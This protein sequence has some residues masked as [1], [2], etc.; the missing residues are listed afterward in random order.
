MLKLNNYKFDH[1]AKFYNISNYTRQI[2][3][4]TQTI[5]AVIT[6]IMQDLFLFGVG[7]YKEIH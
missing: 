5:S 1:I 3:A 7:K 6:N 4:A 2:N